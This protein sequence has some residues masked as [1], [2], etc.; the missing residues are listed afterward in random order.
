MTETVESLC[1]LR[2]TFCGGEW[3]VKDVERSNGQLAL[4]LGGEEEAA[5][6]CLTVNKNIQHDPLPGPDL[7][8][9]QVVGLVDGLEVLVADLGW[10]LHR[11][12]GQ[13]GTHT[14]QQ[15]RQHGHWSLVRADVAAW[16]YTRPAQ[17]THP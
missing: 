17:S 15:H 9:A 12:R 4:H 8:Q 10:L 5:A 2:G 1:I 7:L 16:F 11:R 14:H 13:E 6:E 3:G